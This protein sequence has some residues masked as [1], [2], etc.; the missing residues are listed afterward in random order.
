MIEVKALRNFARNVPKIGPNPDDGCTLE[1]FQ[2]GP[3]GYGYY[4]HGICENCRKSTPNQ[5]PV[6]PKTVQPKTLTQSAFQLFD[7]LI[8]G[9][10]DGALKQGLG[11][12]LYARASKLIESIDPSDV[13]AAGTWIGGLFLRIANN[14][15][16]SEVIR[17]LDSL[18]SVVESNPTLLHKMGLLTTLH[19]TRDAVSAVDTSDIIADK[20]VAGVDPVIAIEETPIPQTEMV[21]DLPTDEMT[22]L[23]IKSLPPSGG[24]TT[25]RSS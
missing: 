18:H 10:A 6:A 25:S 14:G 8:I 17:T 15:G 12:D 2:Y 13:Q 3:D 7:S 24:V 23:G 22:E 20:I 1:G 11:D 21:T 19:Q 4:S 16:Q 5:L 9:L